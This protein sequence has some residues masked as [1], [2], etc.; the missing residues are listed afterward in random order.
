MNAK[1][2]APWSS[3]LLKNQAR[4]NSGIKGSYSD[5]CLLAMW[6]IKILLTSV[7][8]SF[9]EDENRR[10]QVTI[11][12][13]RPRANIDAQNLVDTVSDAIEPGIHVNDKYYDV[14]AVGFLD[15]AN[16]RIEIELF[17]EDLNMAP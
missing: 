3:A 2:V 11:N 4:K 6:G 13:Y 8:R 12:A 15:P 10:I 14:T 16:S 9:D 7:S 5:D 17:Q 1:I